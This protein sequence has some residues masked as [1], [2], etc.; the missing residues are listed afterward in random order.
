MLSL[1]A[2]PG[3]GPGN[4]PNPPDFEGDIPTPIDNHIWFLIIVAIALGIF[5]LKSKKAQ[6]SK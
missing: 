1:H 5:I 3:G 2:Q 4:P 6:T